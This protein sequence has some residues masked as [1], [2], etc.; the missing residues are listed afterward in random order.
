MYALAIHQNVLG[1]V[2]ALVQATQRLQV[3]ITDTSAAATAKKF[4]DGS[5]FGSKITPEFA[6]DITALWR[7]AA[8]QAVYARRSEFQLIDAAEYWLKDLDRIAAPGYEP[9]VDDMLRTRIQT[10]GI[11]EIQFTVKGHHFTLVDVGGQRS[12]R[13]KWI[14][15]FENV[16][17]ILFCAA[18][19]E[20]D[21]VL[22]EDSRTNRIH[23]ALHL[24]REVCTS[25]WFVRSALV[26][27]LNK[28]DLLAQK[29]K[30]GKSITSAWPDYTGGSD[31]D[32]VVA[33]IRRSFL[34]QADAGQGK[35]RDVFA[36]VTTA[37]D[38]ENV[39]RVFEAVE[40]SVTSAAADMAGLT[41]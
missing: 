15:C 13:K 33:F 41:V 10:T 27:F 23:E 18:I 17:A 1:A 19:S 3:P 6:R 35:P 31:F 37:T 4:E 5:L 14:H 16:S 11:I 12:E 28:A 36:Y 8:V 20:F 7:T 40:S 39:K 29:L 38:T 24:F 21:Q 30:A 9:T 25:K 34:A 26:L 2:R 32:E 22:Y